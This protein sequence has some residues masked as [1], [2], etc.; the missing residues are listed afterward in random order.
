MGRDLYACGDTLA[1]GCRWTGFAAPVRLAV[2]QSG[3]LDTPPCW[4]PCWPAQERA[5]LDFMCVAG[6]DQAPRFRERKT[7]E[8]INVLDC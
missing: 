4:R 3:G 1:L 5:E 2:P 7:L 8:R 6:Q